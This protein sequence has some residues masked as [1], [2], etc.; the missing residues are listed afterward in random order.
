MFS[1]KRK[2]FPGKNLEKIYLF[3]NNIVYKWKILVY[4]IIYS[5]DLLSHYYKGGV[6]Y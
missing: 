6:F 2:D 5:D 4:N 1:L 3:N